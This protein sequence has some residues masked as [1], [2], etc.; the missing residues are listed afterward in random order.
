[1]LR[2][3]SRQT[4]AGGPDCV[5][6]LHHNRGSQYPL[7]SSIEDHLFSWRRYSRFRIVYVNLAFGTPFEEMQRLAPRAVV[8]HTSLLSTRWTRELFTAITT[9]L[10]R[11][12]AWQC[13]KV[14][15]PQDEFTNTD[16]L[17]GFLTDVG[18]TH[19]LTCAS[20]QDWPAIYPLTSTT[21]AEFRTVLTGYLDERTIARISALPHPEPRSVDIGY[22][23]WK[24]AYWLGSWGRHKVRVAEVMAAAAAARGMSCDVSL[25][26]SDTLLGDDWFRFLLNCRATVGVEGGASV[27]DRDGTLKDEVARYLD[28]HPEATY[29]ET[30]RACFPGRDGS[31]RL[32]A[33]SPRHLEACATRTAQL[34]VRGDYNGVLRADDHYFPIEPDYSNIDAALDFLE[35]RGRVTSMTDR[36]YDDIVGSGAVTYRRFI[37]D[38]DGLVERFARATGAG[39]IAAF[40]SLRAREAAT[41]WLV[42]AEARVVY[43]DDTR[44]GRALHRVARAGYRQLRTARIAGRAHAR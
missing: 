28:A 27:L 31:L 3:R 5:V 14:A 17:D 10:V 6:V 30:E 8:F 7:R 16:L 21:A 24:A 12:H 19:V 4:P 20:E 15:V 26:D 23:A 40:R 43:N 25:N 11:M 41:W 44:A 36:A 1:M 37:A 18:A 2:A 35:D 13:A 9:P 33:L 32:M 42:R 38:F 34:L 39:S 29:E 22:R